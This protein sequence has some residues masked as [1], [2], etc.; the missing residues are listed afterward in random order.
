M[1]LHVCLLEP[2]IHWNT[3]NTGRT[4]LGAGATLHLVAPLGFSLD[5]REVRR[6]G[7]DYWDRVNPRLWESWETFEGALPGL[8]EA[9][10]LSPGAPRSIF[11]VTFPE[12]VVLVFGRE[13]TGLPEGMRERYKERLLGIPMR[14]PGLRGLNLSTSVAIAAYEVMRQRHRSGGAQALVPAPETLRA[15][16]HPVEMQEKE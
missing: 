3:G 7:L 4:C 2:E 10:F 12:R 6:S 15:V 11:D 13:S 14:D 5:A 9:F 8:G 16:G 1:G